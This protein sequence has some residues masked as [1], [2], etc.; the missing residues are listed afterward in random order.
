LALFGLFSLHSLPHFVRDFGN[1]IHP[2]IIVSTE[3]ATILTAASLFVSARG[4]GLRRRRAWLSATLLQIVLIATSVIHSAHFL[5]RHNA[6]SSIAFLEFGFS[7]L[8]SEFVVLGLLIYFRSDFKTLVDP[9]TR[10][11][12]VLF[13][14]RNMALGYLFG[15]M[16]VYLDSNSFV[17]HP[18]IGNAFEISLKGLIGV[19]GPLSFVSV[20]AQERLEFFLGGIGLLVTISA[21]SRFLRPAQRNTTLS[22]VNEEKIRELLTLYRDSDSLSYFA[23]RDNKAIIWSRNH[24]AAIA[25]SVVNGVMIT[26]GDPIGDQESWPSAIFEFIAEAQRHAWIP[27]IYG[28]SEAAGEIWVRE[29]NFD[30][31]EIGDEAVVKVSDFTLE[32]PE[33]KNV[34]QTLN[35]IHRFNY[36]TVTKSIKEIDPGTRDELAR[37]AQ[38]WRGSS[39][40]RGFSMALGRFC[41]MRDPE[42]VVTWALV[43]GAIVA[44]LQFV[45][46]NQNGLSLDLMRRS[47]EAETGVNELMICATLEFART[48]NIDSVSLNF[49]SFRSIFERGK[50]LGAGPITRINHKFLVYLSRFFQ[51]ESLYRFNA[52]FRPTWQPRFVVFPSAAYLARVGIAILRIESFL[53]SVS[54]FLKSRQITK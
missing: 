18:S 42:C 26:T 9:L 29:T 30:A 4:V 39:S 15:A 21:L 13:F 45:P 54:E 3:V 11:Q 33:M 19:S 36:V 20:V 43:D 37:L 32:G 40:E 52:K 28:C 7:H 31:L 6:R 51:L 14:V 27:A 12:S 38:K 44:L 49:A 25:Y 46:W 23:L 48:Q 50:K 16:I 24:K 22:K 5:F 35:R 17:N 8:L 1:E 41:D 34:R 53:P 47:P 2:T 10:K